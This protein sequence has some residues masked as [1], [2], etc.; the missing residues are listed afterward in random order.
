MSI[1]GDKSFR[2]NFDIFDQYQVVITP[3]RWEILNPVGRSISSE[4]S[5]G[6]FWWK[7]FNYGIQLEKYISSEVKYVF[8][9]IYAWHMRRGL[10]KGNPPDFHNDFGKIYFLGLAAEFFK[11]PTSFIGWSFQ[12]PPFDKSTKKV[13]AK[14]LASG[15]TSDNKALFT[16][17]VEV[18]RL[19]PKYPWFLQTKIDASHDITV[20]V[21]GKK[22][23]CF[24][25]TRSNL[26]SVDWRL[27]IEFDGPLKDSWSRSQFSN[28]ELEALNAFCEKAK[29]HWGRIDFMR[30]F[31]GELYFLEFNANGQWVF[32]DYERKHRLVEE[33]CEYLL[34]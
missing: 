19:H 12:H 16:T 20:F 24:E 17:E 1:I 2:M 9:E 32:L 18:N 25:K 6:A 3:N 11:T 28:S 26:K 30:S 10:I 14:S 23:F 29:I 15:V 22:K 21:C 8:K 31:D 4:T 5:T 34:A 33:V 27:D 7:P 13:V